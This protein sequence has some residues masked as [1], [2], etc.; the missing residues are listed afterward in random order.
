MYSARIYIFENLQTG[1]LD[2]ILPSSMPHQSRFFVILLPPPM[3]P[4]SLPAASLPPSLLPHAPP[5]SPHASPMLPP[6][7]LLSHA[8]S[9]P[10][11]PSLLLLPLPHAPSLS[12]APPCSPMLSHAPPCSPMLPHAPP[13]SLTALFPNQTKTALLE[14]YNHTILSLGGVGGGGVYCVESWV[15]HGCCGDVVV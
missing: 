14:S 15:G 11:A 7:L 9:L 5:C 12:H 8:P 2:V 1:N 13:C 3:L 6:S 10:T 4:P